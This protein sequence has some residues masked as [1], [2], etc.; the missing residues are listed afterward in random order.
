MKGEQSNLPSGPDAVGIM[1]A[2]RFAGIAVQMV[3][4]CPP[5]GGGGGLQAWKEDKVGNTVRIYRSPAIC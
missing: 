1:N 4:Q 5:G 3:T 2:L